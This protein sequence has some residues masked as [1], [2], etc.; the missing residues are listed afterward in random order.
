MKKSPKKSMAVVFWK[1]PEAETWQKE[2]PKV[3]KVHNK[4][5]GSEDALRGASSH[6][7]CKK[8]KN[9]DNVSKHS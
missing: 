9:I 6:R 4:L 5:R 8:K 2:K 1:G 3:M 7:S